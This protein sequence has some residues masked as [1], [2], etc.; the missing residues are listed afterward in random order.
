MINLEARKMRLEEQTQ[1]V[2]QKMGEMMGFS[3]TFVDERGAAWRRE[4]DGDEWQRWNGNWWIRV[5]QQD[6][7]SRE[8]RE[9]SRGFRRMIIHEQNGMAS[10]LR[11]LRNGIK[12]EVEGTN[13]RHL[14]TLSESDEPSRNDE[15]ITNSTHERIHVVLQ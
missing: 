9:I 5:E 15:V 10:L 12:A 7:N 1:W 4:D 14:S 3:E 2:Y 13:R 8:R 11:K 6:L